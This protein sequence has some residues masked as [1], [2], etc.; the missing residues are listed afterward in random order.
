MAPVLHIGYHKTG[1]TWLQKN[2]FTNTESGY[3]MA[4]R[5]EMRNHIIHQNSL[6]FNP[7]RSREA[8]ALWVEKANQLDLIPVFS[9]ERLSGSPHSGGYDS[10][11][12]G[13]RLRTVFP[14]GRVLMV[15]REQVSMLTSAYKQYI[16]GVGA[17][18]V[19][20]YIHHTR[21]YPMFDFAHFHY[22]RLIRHYHRLFTADRVLVLP[23][24]LFQ[25]DAHDFI[26]R[27][28]DFCG[29]KSSELPL[30]TKANPAL[31]ALTISV[32]R[33]FNPFIMRDFPNMGRLLY[34]PGSDGALR[35]AFHWF[36]RA[37]PK[38]LRAHY[39]HRLVNRIGQY[40]GDIYTQSNREVSALLGIDLSTYGYRT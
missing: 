10:R 23:Y 37:L 32:K 40:I 1:S 6:A 8:L 20:D 24:E 38:R 11:E 5:E 21:K 19:H 36:D 2:L 3:L 29:G 12:I 9:D 34:I 31:S 13:E 25:T 15:I 35:I 7:T 28:N 30:Q 26:K 17:A 33:R 39:D 4:P 27:I 14:D 18:S 22:D 16:V